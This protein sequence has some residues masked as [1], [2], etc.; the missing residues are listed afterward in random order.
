MPRRKTIDDSDK[1]ESGE[2]GRTEKFTRTAPA[3]IEAM[4]DEDLGLV[5]ISLRLQKSLVAD[6]KVLARQKG[7]GYQPF[8]RQILTQY[9]SDNAVYLKRNTA[10]GRG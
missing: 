9:A 7:L 6:L 10:S 4:L 5:Q 1:W 3:E 2:L 8:V